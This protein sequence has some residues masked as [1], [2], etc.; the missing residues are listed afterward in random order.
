[1]TSRKVRADGAMTL[2]DVC[3][4]I[5]DC[6]HETAPLQP[7][8]YPSIRTP[9]VG[10]GRLI[11]EGVNRVSQEVYEQWTKRAVPESGDLILAR[12]APAGNVAANWGWTN[13]LSWATYRTSTT[14]S[15]NS[16]FRFPL[17][18]LVGSSATGTSPRWRDWSDCRTRKHA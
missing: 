18:L 14:G 10:R 5:V 3:E 11:L 15:R 4:F 2:H 12:E 8:G 6:L 16:G 1:M 7:T 17:L 9:N 13:C